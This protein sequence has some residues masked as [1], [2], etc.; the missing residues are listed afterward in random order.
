MQRNVGEVKTQ[1]RAARRKRAVQQ[2]RQVHRRGEAKP[3]ARLRR[4]NL[5]AV[6]ALVLAALVVLTL[7]LALYLTEKNAKQTA[8]GALASAGPGGTDVAAAAQP[9]PAA[10]AGAP[11]ET[12]QQAPAVPIQQVEI[13]TLEMPAGGWP[14][15]EFT[16]EEIEML[17]AMLA[18]WAA[19]VPEPPVSSEESEGENAEDGEEGEAAGGQRV[20]VY[21]RDLDSGA[22][23]VYNGAEKFDVA[24]LSKAPYAMYL[25]HLVEQG[26]ASLEETFLIDAESIVGSEENSGRLKNDPNLPRELTLAEMIEYLLRYSDTVAQRVLLQR[27]P[28]QGFAAYAAGLGLHAPADVRGVTSGVISALDAGVYLGA[29]KDY[30]DNGAYGEQLREHLMNTTNPMLRSS[31]PLARKYGWD[32][33]AYHDMAVVY[34]P[35]PY[36]IAILTDKSAGNWED[37]NYFTTV[38][39]AFEQIMAGHW[40]EVELGPDTKMGI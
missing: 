7:V 10:E 2:K 36:L 30:M 11:L 6:F 35:H 27:Y 38:P 19:S 12:P 22:E 28:A 13:P 15:K 21:F 24:S 32:E 8:P 17:D 40:A 3:A 18:Q 16:A 29:L 37:L 4:K 31:W 34:A 14:Q 33:A 20:A 9:P 39:Q 5:L 1:Y 25:Y 26:Q 23:Y